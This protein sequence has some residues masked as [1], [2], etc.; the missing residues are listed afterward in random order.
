MKIVVGMLI[1]AA[2]ARTWQHMAV[3]KIILEGLE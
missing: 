1:S 3:T 2:D